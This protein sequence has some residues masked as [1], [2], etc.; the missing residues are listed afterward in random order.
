LL[1]ACR[2]KQVDRVAICDLA[3]SR[4]A[5]PDRHSV[6]CQIAHETKRAHKPSKNATKVDDQ[7]HAVAD[8]AECVIQFTRKSLFVDA[9][10][11]CD[12]HV[13][14]YERKQSL[15]RS[16]IISG[17]DDV[18]LARVR[19]EAYEDGIQ[20]VSSRHSSR[21]RV[22]SLLE[23]LLSTTLGD[24]AKSL[25][26]RTGERRIASLQL[27]LLRAARRAERERLLNEIFVAEEPMAPAA[28]ALFTRTRAV[29]R[30]PVLQDVQ[31]ALCRDEVLLDFTTSR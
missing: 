31:R 2:C 24:V 19:L 9:W 25:E 29:A 15:V 11:E 13:S 21:R 1:A 4:E 26:L 10:K 3:L 23:L 30:R 20:S 18:L 17:M 22:G 28:T 5:V 7:A 27:G 6:W 14:D 8:P 16:R 12:L